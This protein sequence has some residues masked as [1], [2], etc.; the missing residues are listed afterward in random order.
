MPILILEG[1][2]IRLRDFVEADAEAFVALADDDAMFTY[3]KFRLTRQSALETHLPWLLHEPQ[4]NPRPTYNLA[5]E[6]AVGFAGWAA[7]GGMA[8]GG[9]AEFG[10]YLRSDQW[11][12]GYATEATALLLQI[13]FNQLDRRR[14]FATADP[15][16]VGSIRVLEKSGLDNVGSTTPVQ[17]WRGTRRR[18]LFEIGFDRWKS[19]CSDTPG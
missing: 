5:L 19:L 11:G 17:T 12:R 1:D 10:W 14:M 16:N 2:R 9:D 15:E 4:L 8:E 6:G 13:G 7:V 3:M 18:T